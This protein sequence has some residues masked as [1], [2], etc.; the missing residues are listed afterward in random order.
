MISSLITQIDNDEIVLPAIQRDFV[1]NEDRIAKMFD[2]IMRG[3]PLG[4]ALLW[5]TYLNIKYRE[6]NKDYQTDTKYAFKDNDSEK[7]LKLVLD[8]Q[9]RLQSLYIALE[10]SLNGKR[11]FFDILSGKKSDNFKEVFYV[12]RFLTSN[13]VSELNQN[14]LEYRNS[15][16]EEDEEI[17]TDNT[18]IFIPIKEI[19]NSSPEGR[20]H[21][22]TKWKED[23]NLTDKELLS[24]ELNMQKLVINI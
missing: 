1:W 23:Y 11:L 24:V 5:E 16:S 4:I 14:T 13:K 10:G 9:Q 8:G 7:R 3:Y 20:L 22:K 17:D 19:L 2:S 12:F 21:L 15:E 6:F 18:S